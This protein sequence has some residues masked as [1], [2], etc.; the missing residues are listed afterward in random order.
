MDNEQYINYLNDSLKNIIDSAINIEIKD[1]FSNGIKQG[2]YEA[3]SHLINQSD[4]FEIKNNL[5]KYLQN[6]DP[7]T[8]IT[9]EAD[10]PFT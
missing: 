1:D 2:Y 5:D 10:S 9:G 7:D 3:I 8:L 4:I 6:F